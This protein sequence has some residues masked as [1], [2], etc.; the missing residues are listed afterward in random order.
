MLNTNKTYSE[1]DRDCLK[2][3]LAETDLDAAKVSHPSDNSN[4]TITSLV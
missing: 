2:P 1:L 3:N 4:P